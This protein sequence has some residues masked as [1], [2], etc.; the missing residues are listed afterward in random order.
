ML[1]ISRYCDSVQLEIVWKSRKILGIAGKMADIPTGTLK[2]QVLER[3][4]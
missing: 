3:Y 4:H 1:H 2:I